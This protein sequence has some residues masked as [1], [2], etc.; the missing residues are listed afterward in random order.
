MKI[1]II[2]KNKKGKKALE[3]HKD[4]IKKMSFKDRLIMKASGI[5][6]DL[7][8]DG[9]VVIELTNKYSCN[10]AYVELVKTEIINSLLQNGAEQ[11]D[12]TIEVG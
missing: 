3:I 11:K 10:P 1:T 5:K 6:H 9:F 8:K 12:Y 7:T 2:P 4:E